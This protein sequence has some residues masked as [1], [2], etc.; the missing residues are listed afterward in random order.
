MK[1]LVKESNGQK[2]QNCANYG[3]H[4][5]P[6]VLMLPIGLFIIFL[7]LHFMV[8]AKSIKTCQIME[9]I[10]DLTAWASQQANTVEVRGGGGIVPTYIQAAIA[11][12]CLA[13]A[14]RQ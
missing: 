12:H 13:L 3:D 6:H 5:I 11:R 7:S 4:C 10:R 14:N 8:L 1:I 9:K 2:I